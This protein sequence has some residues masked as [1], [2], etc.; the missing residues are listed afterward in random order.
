MNSS[1]L[2]KEKPARKKLLVALFTLVI[3][4]GAIVVFWPSK[5]LVG[6]IPILRSIQTESEV[7]PQSLLTHFKN[8]KSP[9]RQS[10]LSL[11]RD[12]LALS[13]VLPLQPER[14]DWQLS[15]AKAEGSR[16]PTKNAIPHQEVK[17]DQTTLDLDGHKLELWPQDHSKNSTPDK[18][19]GE[20]SGPVWKAHFKGLNSLG[21][22]EI[23]ERDI[24]QLTPGQSVY[25]LP[26][27]AKTR[28]QD[29]QKQHS[30]QNQDT[31]KPLIEYNW[32]NKLSLVVIALGATPDRLDAPG[33]LSVELVYSK[34][35]EREKQPSPQ[36]QLP[37]NETETKEVDSESIFVFEVSHIPN[38][39]YIDLSPH[40][41]NKIR[42][43]SQIKGIK[44]SWQQKSS[45]RLLILGTQETKGT[46]KRN[47]S[48]SPLSGFLLATKDSLKW[49]EPTLPRTQ[50][51]VQSLSEQADNPNSV[52]T[53]VH[54]VW[55]QYLDKMVNHQQFQKL[56]NIGTL[57]KSSIRVDI[58]PE[59]VSH[60]TL[61]KNFEGVGTR[62]ILTGD[63][64]G[65]VPEESS[66]QLASLVA[67]GHFVHLH[68]WWEAEDI[69]SASLDT[70]LASLQSFSLEK[71]KR[72]TLFAS[73][74]DWHS[75][76]QQELF[77]RTD[78]V[79][80]GIVEKIPKT[81]KPS[82]VVHI[83]RQPNILK[84]EIVQLNDQ[85]PLRYAPGY[86]TLLLQH[87]QQAKQKGAMKTPESPMTQAG[88]VS[89]LLNFFGKSFDEPLSKNPSQ[90][91]KR[92]NRK[93]KAAST[94]QKPES[95]ALVAQVSG[96]RGSLFVFRRG[97]TFVP[98]RLTG[99]LLQ[100][101]QPLFGV[102]LGDIV[103]AK[104]KI[105]QTY[106]D[107]HQVRL[108]LTLELGTQTSEKSFQG[109]EVLFDLRSE[110]PFKGCSSSFPK[111]VFKSSAITREGWM[112]MTARV[113]WTPQPKK[114]HET[115]APQANTV[116]LSCV[117][118]V[119]VQ[120]PLPKKEP[121]QNRK[122]GTE[123]TTKPKNEE[124]GEVSLSVRAS[125]SGKRLPLSK[126]S[127]GPY[128]EPA[129]SI[130]KSRSAF[131]LDLRSFYKRLLTITQP[132][133]KDQASVLFQSQEKR[134]SL[135]NSAT[136]HVSTRPTASVPT[137]HVE[138]KNW[139]Q[140]SR[141]FVEKRLEYAKKL[142]ELKL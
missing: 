48:S 102:P 20:W 31:G 29:P 84:R 117:L 72:I 27:S 66:A 110:H 78:Q 85:V 75:L 68:F 115:D 128:R 116:E 56:Q 129:A 45:G 92:R 140:E 11:R 69:S 50:S 88:L 33:H 9:V 30:S 61:P 59:P 19:Q 125:V 97:W 135:K 77:L 16:N 64:L 118:D 76:Q 18:Q 101:N 1:R 109:Q 131:L 70:Y 7:L 82:I 141:D 132:I 93:R 142:K 114:D 12:I 106:Q 122:K 126:F 86:A 2:K 44:V 38:I 36:E 51:A 111:T 96:D 108:D 90:S 79:I 130:S 40:L 91:K 57:Y 80:V 105:L 49:Q 24:V 22:V 17:K 71:L 10:I 120:N 127:F 6:T 25:M 94:Q 46:K 26:A 15:G 63:S 107:Q 35:E 139:Q 14:W 113:P 53:T 134:N 103:D 8:P 83:A 55:P 28:E 60:R 54:E 5:K 98:H 4:L 67:A 73:P 104:K 34:S 123:Q 124:E 13:D 137:H 58:V 100:N 52:F 121:R 74:E 87:P 23:I 136:V 62:I 112:M 119:S 89:S 21:S 39:Q 32:A 37:Q 138:S 133:S 65:R 42:K 3:V 99:S 81:E 95:T 43:K 47:S 41:R